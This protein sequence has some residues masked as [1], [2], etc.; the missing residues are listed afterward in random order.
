MSLTLYYFHKITL[1][2][3]L[4]NKTRRK[5]RKRGILR[6]FM[7]KLLSTLFLTC[8]MFA[9]FAQ[10][11]LPFTKGVNMLTYFETWSKGDLPNLNKHDEEDFACLKSMGIEVIRLPVHFDLLM[12]PYDTGTIYDFVLEKL[13]QVCDWAEKYQIYLVIDDHSFNTEEYD[14]NP[15]S[16]KI[17]QEHLESVWSQIAYRYKDRSQYIIYEI[18]NEPKSH[19]EIATKWIKIQQNIINL[20]R[21]YDPTRD[22]VVTGADFSNIDG[23]VKMKPYKDSNLIYT[24]HFYEPH[25]FTHQGA[26]WVGKEMMDLEDLPF[27]YDRNRLPKLKGNAKNS[28]VQDAIQNSYSTEG[29]VKYIDNRIK[30]AADWGK[31]N[32]V[33]VWCGEIGAK[34]W[35]NSTDRLAW[36]NATREALNANNIPYCI[37]GLDGSDGLL[38]SADPGFHFPEDIDKDALEAYGF[39]MPEQKLAEKISLNIS[40]EKPYL[41]YDGLQG[42][43]VGKNIWGN[44]KEITKDSTRD[45]CM[46]VSYPGQQ[47][48]CKFILP[49]KITE[50]I[51]ENPESFA[52]SFTVKFTDSKQEFP[53][54]LSD[55]DEGAALP[56][57]N[58]TA[59]I[60][61]SEYQTGEWVTVEIPFSKLTETGAWSEKANQF[62]EPQGKY[63]WNRLRYIYFDFDNFHRKNTRDI[64]I[65]DIVIKKK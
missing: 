31:K 46:S 64:S 59:Q 29:T 24:F 41:V 55:T 35:I 1:I 65:D 17:Y 57:W 18:L 52:I 21:T 9:A 7:K 32:N 6:V 16:A 49:Q 8:C 33:R 58:N 28:W 43:G 45:Y 15:P 12:E 62:F 23:L 61:A 34:T 47:N 14:H 56:P 63:D 30:K 51:A 36:I 10:N 2:I 39:T 44:V 60:K 13:D 48:G 26:T 54:N 5:Y 11:S 37:W 19:G 50:L 27:P 40:A 42:K 53:L 38:T 20:I 25:I 3:V 4:N 22:I